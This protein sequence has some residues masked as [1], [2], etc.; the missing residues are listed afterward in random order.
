[1][2]FRTPFCTVHNAVHYTVLLQSKVECTLTLVLATRQAKICWHHHRPT[3]HL[4]P[5][6][7]SRG[8]PG[9]IPHCF[10]RHLGF[11]V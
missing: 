5:N 9:L 3:Y 6:R 7:Q 2:F 1:M 10:L 4:L 8:R 11:R